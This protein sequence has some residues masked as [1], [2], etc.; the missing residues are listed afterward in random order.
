MRRAAFVPAFFGRMKTGNRL[1]WERDNIGK[2]PGFFGERTEYGFPVLVRIMRHRSAS[3]AKSQA[4]PQLGKAE[5]ARFLGGKITQGIFCLKPAGL[6]RDTV[7]TSELPSKRTWPAERTM[8]PVAQGWMKSANYR[9]YS[10]LVPK[11][12]E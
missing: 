5:P 7:R 2:D 9:H 8:M 6:E 3:P 1:L 12:C 11:F 10:G 4:F